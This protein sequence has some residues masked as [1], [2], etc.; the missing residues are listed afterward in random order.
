MH[1][2]VV[3]ITSCRICKTWTLLSIFRLTTKFM[4][5]NKLIASKLFYIV[6]IEAKAAVA[7]Q[8]NHKHKANECA[9]LA[10][11]VPRAGSSPWLVTI[12]NF[13]SKLT[14]MVHFMIFYL[15]IYLSLFLFSSKF[16]LQHKF[17]EKCNTQT[18]ENVSND[19][20]SKVD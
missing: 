16:P 17:I 20:G 3:F 14:F 8:L 10:V 15:Y 12:L 9:H 13:F 4:H 19:Q 2:S 7:A 18:L 1:S 5:A 11:T 6:K